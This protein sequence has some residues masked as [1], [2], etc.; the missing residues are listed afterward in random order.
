ML[1]TL[2]IILYG[3]DNYM[4]FTHVTDKST[5]VWHGHMIYV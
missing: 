3:A 5:C 4:D 1:N 2:F